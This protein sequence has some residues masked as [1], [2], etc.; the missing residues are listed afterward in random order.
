MQVTI[1]EDMADGDYAIQ[2]KNMMLTEI[3]ASKYYET[4]LVQ[5]KLTVVSNVLGDANGDGVVDVA[6]VVAI[7]NYI[8]EKPADNFNIK[9]ADVNGDE[10]IDAADV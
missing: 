7:V 2:L 10:V 4:K 8:L 9:A 1:A 6:D 5:S 3:D